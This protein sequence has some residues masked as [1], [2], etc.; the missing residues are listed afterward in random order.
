MT[1]GLLQGCCISP[2]LFKIYIARALRL[3]KQKWSGMDI[4]LRNSF[5]FTLQ[6][7]DD[8]AVM[9]NDKEDMEY[10]LRKLIEEYE[11]WG[12]KVNIRRLSTCVLEEMPEAW[13]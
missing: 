7:A 1:N 11:K 3:W 8:Q 5:L 13:N 9:A 4:Q 2:T 6:F 12:L 10:M